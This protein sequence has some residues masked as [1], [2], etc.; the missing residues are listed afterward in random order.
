[1]PLHTM[2]HSKKIKIHATLYYLIYFVKYKNVL[3][4]SALLVIITL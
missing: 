3:R 4:N 1:M 2:S